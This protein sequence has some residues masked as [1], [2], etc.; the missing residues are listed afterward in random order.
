MNTYTTQAQ[1]TKTA[2]SAQYATQREQKAAMKAYSAAM[3][4]WRLG[5][6]DEASKPTIS[7]FWKW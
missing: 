6:K 7:Q 1:V 5:G 3:T 4:A 2:R